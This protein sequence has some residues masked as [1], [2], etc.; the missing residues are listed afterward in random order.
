M[1]AHP[2]LY[3]IDREEK[4]ENKS[5]PRYD[6]ARLM[7]NSIY[8]TI[9]CNKFSAIRCN[10]GQYKTNQKQGPVVQSLISA[11]PGLTLNNTWI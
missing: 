9:H 1:D 10:A 4:L 11:N 7:P 3:F 5:C 6:T 2:F 8:T